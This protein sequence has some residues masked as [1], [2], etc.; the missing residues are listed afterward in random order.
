MCLFRGAAIA[1]SGRGSKRA[2]RV[3]EGLKCRIYAAVGLRE[4]GTMDERRKR[5]EGIG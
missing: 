1:A 4:V 5:R 3:R 2:D